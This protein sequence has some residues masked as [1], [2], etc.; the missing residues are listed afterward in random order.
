VGEPKKSAA[1]AA[2]NLPLAVSLFFFLP[3]SPDFLLPVGT[4]MAPERAMCDANGRLFPWWGARAKASPV[5]S[6]RRDEK[7]D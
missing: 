1:C 6:D 4:A 3:F 5:I 7:K 2:L